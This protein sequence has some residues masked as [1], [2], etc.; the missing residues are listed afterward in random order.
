[1][2]QVNTGNAG[3]SGVAGCIRMHLCSRETSTQ[4]RESIS[5]SAGGRRWSA[6]K[7]KTCLHGGVAVRAATKAYRRNCQTEPSCVWSA[8]QFLRTESWGEDRKPVERVP[9]QLYR[10]VRA[11]Q[12]IFPAI[13]L[14]GVFK[15]KLFCRRIVGAQ[16]HLE[17]SCGGKRR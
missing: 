16:K 6:S 11:Y 12:L 14:L 4:N 3:V 1:M 5:R 10:N 9:A 15:G 17:F 8:V 2:R 13:K 7:I